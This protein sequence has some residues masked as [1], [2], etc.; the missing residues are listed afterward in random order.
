MKI[1]EYPIIAALA[2]V[3]F[4]S[5]ASA[6]QVGDEHIVGYGTS[7]VRKGR[8]VITLSFGGINGERLTAGE[9][10]SGVMEGDVLSYG[11]FKATAVVVDDELH[12]VSGGEV[13]D[14]TELPEKG[15]SIVI[16]RDQDVKTQITFAGQ[17]LVPKVI[18]QKDAPQQRPESNTVKPVEKPEMYIADFLSYS[19]VRI[20]SK[21]TEGTSTGT[22]FFY[23]CREKGKPNV[24]IPLIVTNWHVISN[25]VETTLV[26]TK[27][28]GDRP[29][30]KTTGYVTFYPPWERWIR[31]PSNDV[32]MAVLPLQPIVNIIRNQTKNEIFYMPY[33]RSMIPGEDEF[34]TITQLD[35]VAMIGY[36]NG[37]WDEINNQPIFRKGAVATR[38]SINYKGKREY[39]V[40]MSVFPGSSG[41]PILLVSEGSYYDRRHRGMTLGSRIRLLGVNYAT[42]LNR[43]FNKD[44]V[45]MTKAGDPEYLQPNNLGVIIHPSRLMEMEDYVQ[46]VLL[47]GK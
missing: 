12:W 25:A 3:C 28:E 9:I 41:S 23:I 30:D 43:I 16:E 13:V 40:D 1:L 29:S 22:G 27:K 35:E 2:A 8:N 33:D 26:F 7:E 6:M 20:E 19:T 36:P 4:V 42:H 24:T 10:L 39:L 17:A 5:T 37:R 46:Q 45:Q 47:G 44:E 31:H 15:Q 38:P 34:R 32:D 14:A 11:D 21:T 18:Q